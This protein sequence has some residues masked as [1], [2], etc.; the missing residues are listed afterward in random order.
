MKPI[1]TLFASLA[2]GTLAASAAL[3]A[4]PVELTPLT[5]DA[6][7]SDVT[8][9]KQPGACQIN[10]VHVADE[11]FGKDGIGADFP[12]ATSP[13][14]PWLSSGLDSLKAYGFTVQHTGAPIPNAINLDVKLIRAYTW[15]GHMRINGM[16][17]V[18]VDMA[19]PAGAKSQKFRAAGSKSNMWGA[20]TEHVTALNYAINSMVQKMAMSLQSECMQAKLALR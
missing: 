8:P 16:V 10:V 4:A 9:V 6:V 3:A 17:A 1:K 12:V 5:Y 19:S 13:T 11:R 15:F 20:K 14:D 18:D 2:I 7:T